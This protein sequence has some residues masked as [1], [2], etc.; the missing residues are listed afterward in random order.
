MSWLEHL[1]SNCFDDW[2]FIFF[3]QMIFIT[4]DRGPCWLPADQLFTRKTHLDTCGH[5]QK[6]RWVSELWFIC[7]AYVSSVFSHLS[8]HLVF[9]GGDLPWIMLTQVPAVRVV[10]SQVPPPS[11]FTVDAPYCW[12]FWLAVSQMLIK[13]VS[14]LHC[15]NRKAGC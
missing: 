13:S 9:P 6:T 12:T 15:K 3:A 1:S 11:L 8:S 7:A 4:G 5:D 10:Q 2:E 14:F